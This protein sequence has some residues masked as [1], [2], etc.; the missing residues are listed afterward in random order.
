MKRLLLPVLAT[1]LAF[2]L[3]LRS[4]AAPAPLW[5]SELPREARAATH[6]TWHCHT[7]GCDH[8]LVLPALLTRDDQLFGWTIRALYATGRVLVPCDA[9]LGYGAANLLVFCIAWPGAMLALW[10]AA[11][12]TR[13]KRLAVEGLS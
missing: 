4:G 2:V 7:H 9:A 3:V 8:R 6:C 12:R 13:A 11:L 5:R 1:C 10:V